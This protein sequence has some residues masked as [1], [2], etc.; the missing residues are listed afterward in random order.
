MVFSLHRTMQYLND[1][2]FN[3]PLKFTKS[4]ANSEFAV[5]RRDDALFVFVSYF[6]FFIFFG[7]VWSVL[8][9]CNCKSRYILGLS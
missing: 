4:N 2:H 1:M 9:L 5:K 3:T 7:T 6:L 8:V